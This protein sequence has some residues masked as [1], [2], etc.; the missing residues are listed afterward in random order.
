MSEINSS[1]SSEAQKMSSNSKATRARKPKIERAP[2]SFRFGTQSVAPTATYGPCA[3]EVT[4]A[5]H[6]VIGADIEA[7]QIQAFCR[8]FADH[9][10]VCVING[11][12]V[13]AGSW[14]VI[15]DLNTGGKD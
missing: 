11:Y 12:G 15:F 8:G 3:F 2:G 13:F 6:N 7:E 14:K 9:K 10:E 1:S 4:I 5:T